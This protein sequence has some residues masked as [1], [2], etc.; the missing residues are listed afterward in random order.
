MFPAPVIPEK[1]FPAYRR[2][3]RPD[4]GSAGPPPAFRRAPIM[5]HSIPET[6]FPGGV[7]HE[8]LFRREAAGLSDPRMGR[9]VVRQGGKTERDGRRV[10][11]DLLLPASVH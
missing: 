11:R 10:G 9:G 6:S 1:T 2:R 4:R 7:I 3:V 5:V 8:G